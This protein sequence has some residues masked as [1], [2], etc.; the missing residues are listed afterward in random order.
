MSLPIARPAVMIL[1]G[2]LV[3]SA[4][5]IAGSSRTDNDFANALSEKASAAIAE[6]GGGPVT[7]TFATG[8]GWPSRHPLLSRGENLNEDVRDKVAKAVAAIP[9]VGGV[10]W[11]DGSVV[12]DAGEMPLSP[13]H[14][15]DDVNALLRARTIRFEESSSAIEVGSRELLDEV[16][17]ALRPCL[18]SI[19]SITGHTDKSGPEPG[20]LQLSE[21][22]AVAVRDALIR[23]GIPA[24]GLRA[25]GVGSA[26]P[27]EG[28]TPQDPANRRIEFAVVATTPLVPTPVDTPGAR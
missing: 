21:E 1:A 13:L 17:T 11:S 19:I 20:N 18:G 2:A 8:R 15:Q 24:D 7:A 25:R 22:R 6:N 26:R 14:C 27:V 16:A 23:R 9:G 28:L 3:V 10:R 5:A 12:A 4:I